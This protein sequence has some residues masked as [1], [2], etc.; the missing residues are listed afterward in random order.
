M[1]RLF[2]ILVLSVILLYG[3]NPLFAHGSA[4]HTHEKSELSEDKVE[5]I[6]KKEIKRLANSNK[7]SRTWVNASRVNVRIK[8]FGNY[9]EWVVIYKNKLVNDKAKQKLYI[10]VTLSGKVS[11]ANYTG[12]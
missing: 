6:A 7:I 3:V 11:G 5:S 2:K 8:T 9:D 4:G 1:K 12:K 10:F